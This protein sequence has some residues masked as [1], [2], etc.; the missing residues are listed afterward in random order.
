MTISTSARGLSEHIHH[1]ASGGHLR[2]E[3]MRDAI[4]LIMDGQATQA[5]ISAL[6]VALRFNGET[7]A[8]LVGAARAMRERA[9][10]V[11][12]HLESLMDVCGTGGDG[13]GSFNVSTAVA[14]V[15]AGAGVAVAKHGNR[16][17]SSRCGSADV[18]ESLGVDFDSASS[19][20]QQL[21]ERHGI[22]F[23]FAQRHHPAMRIVAPVRR[24]IGIRTLFNLLGPLTNPARITHQVVGVAQY[25]ALAIMA[26]ALRAMGR[27]R[28]AVVHSQDGMDEV[29]LASS[30]HIMEWD[31][32]H[33]AQFDIEPEMFEFERRASSEVAGGSPTV[34]ARLIEDV[35][36][37]RPGPHR[38]IVL[39]NAGVALYIA[40]R[41]HDIREGIR[42]AEHSIDSG[43]ARHSLQ[44]LV[45]SK[46]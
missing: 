41:G 13:S 33:F 28:A 29:S 21:L 24:E 2:E 20:A 18:L 15:V 45:E 3:A 7:A 6:L 27:E 44:M 30:T 25:S 39:L 16:A 26:D 46:A 10:R 42:A 19:C 32:T 34:N 36:A 22:A 12:C 14:F 8:E 17:M 1:C 37:G 38:D 23:L 31:G 5:Q 35:L 9:V 43:A 4:G 40:G 11:E